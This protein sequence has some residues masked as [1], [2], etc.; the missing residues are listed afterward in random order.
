MI[1]FPKIK[2]LTV[3]KD[4]T[5]DPSMKTQRVKESWM[6]KVFLH[7]L[8]QPALDVKKVTSL[9]FKWS[10]ESTRISG[11]TELLP[12]SGIISP[13]GAILDLVKFTPP[14]SSCSTMASKWSHTL[15]SLLKL[16][17]FTSHKS[18]E[19]HRVVGCIS[20]SFLFIINY[21][22]IPLGVLLIHS[23]VERDFDCFQFL[24]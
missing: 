18:F 22:N 12:T 5:E 1:L 3:S 24:L 14:S 7:L 10:Q 19:I 11:S 2:T 16:A 15:C 6:N 8:A 13:L 9:F 21:M 23:P 4:L 17:S 20:T